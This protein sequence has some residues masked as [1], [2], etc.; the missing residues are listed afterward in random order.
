[1]FTLTLR[2]NKKQTEISPKCHF[3]ISYIWVKINHKMK[4]FYCRLS[5]YS[6]QRISASS[7]INI[8]ALR[9]VDPMW[10]YLVSCV[11]WCLLRCELGHIFLCISPS[12]SRSHILLCISTVKVLAPREQAILFSH[13]WASRQQPT[14]LPQ[15]PP[16]P[17]TTIW[18]LQSILYSNKYY[19]IIPPNSQTLSSLISAGLSVQPSHLTRNNY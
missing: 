5:L 8:F 11:S 18:D 1:M 7:V 13:R 2:K 15:L 10:E 9:N 19:L 12:A 6:S 3:V 17:P 16:P 14:A 4:L